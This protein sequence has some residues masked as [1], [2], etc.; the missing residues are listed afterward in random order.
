MASSKGCAYIYVYLNGYPVAFNQS[1]N[2]SYD[3]SSSDCTF[4][5]VKKNDVIT[6][7][8]WSS[9]NES[10]YSTSAVHCYFYPSK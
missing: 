1:M 8:M 2:N 9:R 5:P 7:V 3:R 10:P 4:I 6:F